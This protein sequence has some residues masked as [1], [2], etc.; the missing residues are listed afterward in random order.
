MLQL[1]IFHRNTF[2]SRSCKISAGTKINNKQKLN[3]YIDKVMEKFSF[4]Y[5]YKQ[6]MKPQQ[7]QQ[8]Q[9]SIQSFC[10]RQKKRTNWKTW[11]NLV[12]LLVWKLLSSGVSVFGSFIQYVQLFK[13]LNILKVLVNAFVWFFLAIHSEGHY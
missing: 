13:I 12:N 2:F 4:I 1:I 8:Y 10:M 5:I 6:R 11:W 7:Q 3:V 9:E